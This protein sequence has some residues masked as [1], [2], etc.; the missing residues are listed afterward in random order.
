M[1]LK[2]WAEAQR[3]KGGV[4]K[5]LYDVMVND[6]SSGAAVADRVTT[7]ETAVGS[8]DTDSGSLKKRCKDIETNVGSL[9]TAVGDSDSGLVKDVA[10]VKTAIGDESTEGTILARIKAL[11]DA[12]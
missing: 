11:E 1:T 6:D 5:Y 9:Q 10:D 8:K 12:S 7:L 2:S 4:V 3:H